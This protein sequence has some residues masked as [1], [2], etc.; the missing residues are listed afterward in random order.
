[1]K[2][3]STVFKK[4]KERIK[5]VEKVEPADPKLLQEDELWDPRSE[6]RV[7]VMY[8]KLL[9]S[10]IPENSL[11]ESIRKEVESDDLN[12]EDVRKVESITN[13]EALVEIHVSVQV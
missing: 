13:Y 9:S 11:E 7:D 2:R 3:D 10:D 6:S 4:M 8:A 5:E 12:V 1:M